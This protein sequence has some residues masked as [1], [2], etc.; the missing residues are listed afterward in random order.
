MRRSHHDAQSFARGAY[1]HGLRPCDHALDPKREPAIGAH[2][3]TPRRG[4]THHGIYVGSGQV[5]QYR[6]LFHGLSRGP[7]EEI[8]LSHF[9][10]GRALWV[11]LEESNW[12][13]GNEVVRRARLRLGENCYHVLKNNCE[14]FCEWCVRGESRSYQVDELI[15]PY[16]RAWHTYG[17]LLA[18]ALLLRR[19]SVEP[20]CPA[21][22]HGVAKLMACQLVST[23]GRTRPP[24]RFGPRGVRRHRYRLRTAFFALNRIVSPDMGH[25]S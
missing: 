24:I 15:A 2:L 9:A 20:D 12:F 1:W 16:R 25:E 4:Y 13:D 23:A 5:V 21:A 6:G 10:Q 11:R 8:P 18:R 19:N 14:H 22:H 3:V 17:Q 7:V